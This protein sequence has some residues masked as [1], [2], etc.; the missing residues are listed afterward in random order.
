[1]VQP[2]RLLS[3][4]SGIVL[5]GTF[6]WANSPFERLAPRPLVPV[7]HRPLIG[8]ALS[9]L[10]NAGVSRVAICANRNSRALGVQLAA[11]ASSDLDLAYCEDAMPRGAAGCVRDAAMALDGEQFVV[12][13]AASIPTVPLLDLLD[14]HHASG[15]AA[16]VAVHLESRGRGQSPLQVPAGV[17]V[18]SRRVVE[19]ISTHGFVDI[20]EHLI[21]SLARARERVATFSVPAPVPRVLDA[22]TYLAV[23]DIVTHDTAAGRGIAT[24]YET[25]GEALVHREARVAADVTFA[26]PVIVAAGTTIGSRAVL[27]GPTSIGCDAVIAPGALVSRSAIWRRSVID[28]GAVVDRSIVGDDGHVGAGRH[29]YRAVVPGTYRRRSVEMPARVVAIPR[30]PRSA[31]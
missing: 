22:T 21:P 31:A 15:A 13:D 20:K 16:T 4:T 5:A 6:P 14:V 23:N 24:G 3:S 7:A 18:L 28:A 8:Y 27:V 2:H 19:A 17:Y 12:T 29:I 10:Q 11:S 26:G 1:M 25:R 9:W 30:S